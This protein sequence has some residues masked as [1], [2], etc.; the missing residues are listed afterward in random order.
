MI[1]IGDIYLHRL[2]ITLRAP[3]RPTL[4]LV[5][6][7]PKATGDESAVMLLTRVRLPPVVTSWYCLAIFIVFIFSSRPTVFMTIGSSLSFGSHRILSPYRV[8]HAMS[9]IADLRTRVVNLKP[10]RK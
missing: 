7:R 6:V 5:R 3:T 9:N 2:P 4:S 8:L 1:F 10:K